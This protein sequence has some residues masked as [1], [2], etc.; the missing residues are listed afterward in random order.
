MK[1]V[2]IFDRN[3]EFI[4]YQYKSIIK[5]IKCDFE[6]IVFNNGSN[7]EQIEKINEIC[8]RLNIKT[9]KLNSGL[10]LHN[11]YDPSIKAGSAL[12]EAF[13]YLSGRIFKIDSDMFFINDINFSDISEDLLF[14]PNGVNNDI[15][16]SGIFGINLDV[17]KDELN[18]LPTF[19]DTFSE[20]KNIVNNEKYTKKKFS[21]IAF[22]KY[23][24]DIFQININGDCLVTLDS[25]KIINCEKKNYIT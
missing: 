5:N 15:I 2:T 11:T 16:W 8:E 10:R 18:F 24:D 9:I 20:S 3:E 13:S 23:L 12:N 4:E 17:V 7:L 19:G 6:Y 1:I 14:I 25:S 22:F 21:L